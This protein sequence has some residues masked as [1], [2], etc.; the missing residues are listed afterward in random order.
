MFLAKGGFSKANLAVIGMK[1]Y[2]VYLESMIM[3][4]SLSKNV[5][6]AYSLTDDMLEIFRQG[7]CG[8]KS[9]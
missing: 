9:K 6:W 3:A 5:V 7:Q 1:R 2:E 4:I 8:S